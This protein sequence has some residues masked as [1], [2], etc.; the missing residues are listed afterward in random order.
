MT[1]GG[2]YGCPQD[3]IA[4][5]KLGPLIKGPLWQIEAE[6]LA[7]LRNSLDQISA[8]RDV[9]LERLRSYV[10]DDGHK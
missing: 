4:S 3:I 8:R 2:G 5:I 7:E 1:S 6:Q 10:E 9:T